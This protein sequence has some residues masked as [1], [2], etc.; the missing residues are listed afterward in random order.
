MAGSLELISRTTLSTTA[1]SVTFSGIASTYQDLRIVIV[2]T[3]GVALNPRI[4]FNS[5]TGTNYS[6]TYLKGDGANAASGRGNTTVGL[7]TIGNMDTTLPTMVTVDVFNYAGSIY[8]TVLSSYALDKNAT[9]GSGNV[10]R[11]VVM[12][13]NTAAVTSVTFDTGGSTFK[14]GTTISLFGV[15]G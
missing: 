3:T 6:Y 5:D 9:D 14:A 15:K 8:K 10:G 12:W 1:A 11:N 7:L 4:Q 13:R 2:G